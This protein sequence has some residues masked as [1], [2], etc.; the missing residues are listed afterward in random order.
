M[1][2]VEIRHPTVLEID[3]IVEDYSNEVHTFVFNR[4]GDSILGDG[5]WETD[6]RRWLFVTNTVLEMEI[7]LDEIS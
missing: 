6:C 7:A 2:L 4:A 1:K 3:R 5:A